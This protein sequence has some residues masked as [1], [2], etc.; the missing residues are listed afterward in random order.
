MGRSPKPQTFLARASYRQRR[1]R[2]AAKVLPIVG[3]LLF[4]AP[5]LWPREAVAEGGNGT[6]HAILYLFGVWTALIVVAFV[7]ARIIRP[8]EDDDIQQPPEQS[9]GSGPQAG[10]R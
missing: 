5:L 10:G 1:L 4:M 2:D 7:L 8:T 3:G 6:S 9:P